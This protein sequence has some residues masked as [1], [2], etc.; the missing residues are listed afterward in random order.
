MLKDEQ[1]I[2]LNSIFPF[3]FSL[4]LALNFSCAG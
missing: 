4:R 1:I 2:T 3:N